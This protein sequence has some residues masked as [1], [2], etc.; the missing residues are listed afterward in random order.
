M[1]G[2]HS[3]EGLSEWMSESGEERQWLSEMADRVSGRKW[4]AKMGRKNMEVREK[5]SRRRKYEGIEK[6]S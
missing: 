4:G 3:T 2:R 6:E 5:E 1:S